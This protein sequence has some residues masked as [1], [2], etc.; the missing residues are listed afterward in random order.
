[1][2]KFTAIEYMIGGI[3]ALMLSGLLL[4][5]LPD[6]EED[7]KDAVEQCEEFAASE[8]QAALE[9]CAALIDVRIYSTL[10][11]LGCVPSTVE[12]D[13]WDCSGVCGSK[14]FIPPGPEELTCAAAPI[15]PGNMVC[16]EGHCLRPESL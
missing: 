8:R 3:I 16:K 14:A 13:A 10:I 6:V 2:R 5:C 9:Q 15:C 7:I 12:S 4:S 11:A 1:M